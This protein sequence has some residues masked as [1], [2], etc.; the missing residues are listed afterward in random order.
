MKRNIQDIRREYRLKSLNETEIDADPI[1]QFDKWLDEAL[2]AEATEPTAMTLST[3]SSEGKPTARMVLLKQADENGFVFY[4][5]Y[6][7]RKGENLAHSPYA[8]LVF[9]WPELERQVRLEGVAE[10]VSKEDSDAYFDSRPEG[11]RIGAIVSPQSSEIPGRKFLE[12]LF[13]NYEKM[14]KD[15][16]LRRPENWGGYRIIPDRI[17]FWQGRES[18]LHDRIEF[19]RMNLLWKIKRLAP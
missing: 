10:K 6:N 2:E 4:T 17:E 16:P 15:K 9:Y 18:R 3:I 19:T 11:S 14:N 7:S 1:R 13:D 5:N 12:E 8:A